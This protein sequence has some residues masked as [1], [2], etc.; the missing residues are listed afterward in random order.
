[1]KIHR[2]PGLGTTG[3]PDVFLYDSS[4]NIMGTTGDLSAGAGASSDPLTQAF[5]DLANL[6]STDLSKVL[7][8]FT[9][10]GNPLVASGTAFS[11]PSMTTMILIGLLAFAGIIALGGK[12]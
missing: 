11:G 6:P 2:I 12:R 8:T 7:A 1:M 5:S 3:P 9:M 10:G 4:G